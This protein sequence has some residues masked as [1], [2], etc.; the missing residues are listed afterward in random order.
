[1]KKLFAA[2]IGLLI[3]GAVVVAFPSS[4]PGI[5]LIFVDEK[6]RPLTEIS[7]NAEVQI[8]IDALVPTNEIYRTVYHGTLKKPSSLKFWDKGNTLKLSPK[9]GVFKEVITQWNTKHPE[10]IDTSLV[11]SVWIFDYKNGKLY[12][13]FSVVNYNTKEIEMDSRRW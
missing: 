1:M 9:D 10:G 3:I 5:Q 8:Q 4:H 12:R 11:V 2:L 7:E 6:G 13:G